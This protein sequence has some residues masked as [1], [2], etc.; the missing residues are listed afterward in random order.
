MLKVIILT[1]K[2]NS[3]QTLLYSGVM[4]PMKHI[5]GNTN[6]GCFFFWE[7]NFPFTLYKNNSAA[8]FIYF[9]IKHPVVCAAG[10]NQRE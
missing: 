3:V 10:E 7:F 1:I 5:D 2:H 9:K 4:K 8:G 6:I